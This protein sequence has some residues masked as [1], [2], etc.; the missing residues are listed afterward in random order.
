MQLANG[1]LPL[2]YSL[3]MLTVTLP[4]LPAMPPHLH[5]VRLEVVLH[6]LQGLAG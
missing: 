6:S 4:Q 3:V 5:A 1:V 2:K